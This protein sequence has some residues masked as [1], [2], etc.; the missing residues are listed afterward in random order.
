MAPVGGGRNIRQYG[1]PTLSGG[2]RFTVSG[3]RPFYAHA[4]ISARLKQAS[5]VS[6]LNGTV[7]YLLAPVEMAR[8][9]TSGS[10]SVVA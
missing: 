5:S 8:D 3:V 2:D 4:V 1:P 6:R 9:I 10:F 7:M